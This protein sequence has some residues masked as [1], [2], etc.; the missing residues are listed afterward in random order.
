MGSRYTNWAP[1]EAR[2][3]A[4][5]EVTWSWSWLLLE[6]WELR[7]LFELRGEPVDRHAWGKWTRPGLSASSVERAWLRLRK[8]LA[9]A[10]VPMETYRRVGESIT[11]VVVT[12]PKTELED[13]VNERR[14]P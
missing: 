10:G 2:H 13:W 14:H 5:R 8:R 6:A 1:C 3:Q 12:L 11:G 7:H 9:A 4:G